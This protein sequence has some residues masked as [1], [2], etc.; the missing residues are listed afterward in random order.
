MDHYSR[1]TVT[2]LIDRDL[3]P[4]RVTESVDA[5]T[6]AEIRR[7]MA[8]DWCKWD[9]QVG[10]VCTI[11]PFALILQLREWRRLAHWAEE[12][13]AELVAA[14]R[15]LLHRPE[16][17][18]N[19]G[20]PRKLR[21]ALHNHREIPAVPRSVRFDFHWTLDGW[22]ISEAN[23]D[24]PGGYAEAGALPAMMQEH[25]SGTA[26]ARSPGTTYARSIATCAE[27]KPIALISAAGFMEDHQ[28]V[29]HLMKQLR[30]AGAEAS[31]VTIEQIIWRDGIAFLADREL[32]CIV[33]FFQGEW[34]ANLKTPLWRNFLTSQTP[35]TNPAT[36]IF[37]ESKRFPLVWDALSAS[38]PRWRSLLPE[39][40]EVRDADLHDDAWLLKTAFC[41]TGDTVT[42]RGSKDWL[43]ARFGARLNPR[44]WLAQ[45]RFHPIAIETPLGPVNP[46]I[47]VYVIDG[48]AAGIYGRISPKR[49]IDFEAI[50]VA[51]LVESE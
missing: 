26:S 2:M 39:T 21:R 33:R 1:P 24:V 19:L 9:P 30:F 43:R 18:A 10:D 37:S 16:P 34:L 44:S 38:M 7:R 22:R 12:L 50:D 27:R 29:A 4:Y 48:H 25:F 14:E 17:T 6:S 32:G 40:R 36:A 41:N 3:Q 49:V 42:L 20:I 11:A 15:E 51:V 31:H 45:R 13:F 28:V 46:C 47:G 8:I 23:S 5:A 35:I